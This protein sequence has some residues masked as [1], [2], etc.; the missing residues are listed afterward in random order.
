MG[1]KRKIEELKEEEQMVEAMVRE[2][3]EKQALEEPSVEEASSFIPEDFLKE[4]MREEEVSETPTS[5][6]PTKEAPTLTTDE[7]LMQM[8]EEAA[9]LGLKEPSTHEQ[10]EE[11]QRW[12]PYYR[13]GAEV[14][15]LGRQEKLLEH[16]TNI[17]LYKSQMK[18]LHP[19]KLQRFLKGTGRAWKGVKEVAGPRGKVPKGFYIPKAMP[20]YYVPGARV[21]KLTTPPGQESPIGEINRPH[22]ES[23]Q[24][25]SAPPPTTA[26]KVP[27]R[28]V[29]RQE[30]L[31]SALGRLRQMGKFPKVDWAVY[32]EIH[33]NGD[34]DTPSHVR[35]EVAQLGFSKKE[36]DDSLKR[37]RNL[38][39]IVPTGQVYNGEKELMVAGD[40][41]HGH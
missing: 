3:E 18:K 30:G 20:E 14:E 11:F 12:I 34:I 22:L 37:L 29:E 38:G 24:R 26:I 16:K 8:K 39:L 21:R 7:L 6:T 31:G 9:R 23:L 10:A 28:D 33:A 35:R 32:S 2:V 13:K 4:M 15:E 36:I 27:F 40:T 41:H 17:E 5:E 25:A 1:K 19:S